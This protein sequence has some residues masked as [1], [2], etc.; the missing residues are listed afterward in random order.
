MR[1]T[2]ANPQRL[3]PCLSDLRRRPPSWQPG[4]ERLPVGNVHPCLTFFNYP[5]RELPFDFL[6]CSE[7]SVD[8]CPFL[9]GRLY[10]RIGLIGLDLDFHQP[11][12]VIHRHVKVFFD[13]LFG[14]IGY[15][16]ITAVQFFLEFIQVMWHIIPSLL[17]A[18]G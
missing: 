4:F 18:N 3:L 5:G 11:E 13:L 8:F 7:D 2:A 14:S 10:I 16:R 17:V 6:G 15:I 9:R 1:C 12:E